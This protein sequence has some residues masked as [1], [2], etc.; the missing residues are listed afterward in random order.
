MHYNHEGTP[1][2]GQRIPKELEDKIED[3]E[4]VFV[5]HLEGLDGDFW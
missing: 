1:K 2:T 4:E 5:E 3:I